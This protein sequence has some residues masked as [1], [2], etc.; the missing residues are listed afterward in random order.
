MPKKLTQENFIQKCKEK[1]GELYDYSH[2]EY[3][4]MKTPIKIICNIHGYFEQLPWRHLSNS[5]GCTTCGYIHSGNKRKLD[6]SDFIEQA[7]KKHNF[8]YNYSLTTYVSCFEKVKIICP[9]HGIFLQR[10]SNHLFGNGCAKCRNLYS[11]EEFIKKSNK[12]HIFKYDYSLS[13][14]SHNRSLVT[15]ICPTHGNFKQIARCH[16]EGKGCPKCKMSKGEKA[17]CKW[18]DENK[19]EYTTQKQFDNCIN[20]LTK[21]KLTYDFYLNKKNI[22]IEFD[23]IQHYK[24]IPSWTKDTEQ[25]F[26]SRVFRDFIKNEYAKSNRILLIRIRFDQIK[27]IRAI[28]EE[29]ITPLT[30]S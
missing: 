14:Y 24:I 26:K 2:V 11:T 22:L 23:G 7:N 8:K 20:P 3:I 19:I 15:I 12:I 4:N 16:L 9:I 21:S 29:L 30:N 17:I 6:L 25:D 10:P 27:S 28:L 13:D 5:I 18:L 1:H